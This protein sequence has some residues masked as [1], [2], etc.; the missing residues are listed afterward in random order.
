ML[1]SSLRLALIESFGIFTLGLIC[2]LGLIGSIVV[3]VAVVVVVVVNLE[4]FEVDSGHR[5]A[6]LKES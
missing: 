1:I 2:H 6:S 4:H 3:V 5:L